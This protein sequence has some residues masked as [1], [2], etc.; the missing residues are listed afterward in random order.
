[1]LLRDDT[2]AELSPRANKAVREG[3]TELL[4]KWLPPT[5]DPPGPGVS[6]LG[7]DGLWTHPGAGSSTRLCT[8]RLH[9]SPPFSLISLQL[10][11]D[12]RQSTPGGTERNFV[13]IAPEHP[14]YDPGLEQVFAPDPSAVAVRN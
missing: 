9:G 14:S 3:H 11:L 1:M 7:S 13:D 12:W 4:R 8:R 10:R 2:G 6:V 5:S